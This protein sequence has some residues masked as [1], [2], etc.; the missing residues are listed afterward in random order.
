L[1]PAQL[2]VEV[3]MNRGINEFFNKQYTDAIHTFNTLIRSRPDMAEPHVWRGRAKY[4]IGDLVG[5]EFDLT[6]AVKLDTYNPDAYYYRGVVKATL[7]DYYSAIEDFKKS[8]QR[9]PNNPDVYFSRG[10]TR[11]YMEEFEAAI[12]DFDTLI[13]LRPDAEQS[14]LN[15]AQA[16]ANLNRIDEAIK[17]C[18]YVIKKNRFNARAFAQRALLFRDQGRFDEAI[19][20]FNQAIKLDNQNPL[21]YF[22]R[23]LA[24]SESGDTLSALND[25]NQVVR[26]DPYND[27]T[28]FNRSLIYLQSE[29]YDS[30]IEDLQKVLEL[31]PQNLHSW[32]NLGVA[33]LRIE[34]Y[35]EAAKSLTAAINILPYYL[36]AYRAR[37]VAYENLGKDDLA[38]ADFK[39]INRLI[40]ALDS[41]LDVSDLN[42]KLE[43]D[44]AYIK[45]II[46][47]EAD[48]QT[49]NVTDGRVQNQ[50]VIIKMLPNY[51]IQ[52]LTEDELIELERKFMN[53]N[54]RYDHLDAMVLGYGFGISSDENKLPE[55]FA[56]RL[57]R[58]SDS[59]SYFD[60]FNA[61]N[62]FRV[63]TFNAM[64]RNYNEALTSFDRAIE[65]NPNFTEA[66]FNRAN[67]MF[68]LIEHRFSMEQDISKV[69]ISQ[70]SNSAGEQD[71][72]EELPDFSQVIA[73]LDKVIRV[74]P[75]FSIAYYNRGNTKNRRRD[76]QGAV[77][78]YTAAL[79][80][81]PDFAEAYYNR[82]ITL[83]YFNHTR[84]ACYDLSKAGE[85]GIKEAYN[86]IKRFCNK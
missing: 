32:Y 73:D 63:G 2:N 20:D 11:L 13:L 51:S 33:Y 86:V 66:Y 72:R 49:A 52:Y 76:F 10:V 57:V 85:L 75:K 78:D 50:R 69:T 79:A 77:N 84:E 39:T 3:F 42:R 67:I 22:N 40:D 61:Q 26:L 80:L 17:D 1:L 54:I 43:I 4:E 65:L 58:K 28:Y 15:R 74:N 70:G 53:T 29:Q 71:Q 83:I 44:S 16:K 23:A 60:P 46:D 8:L 36:E 21:T 6:R 59:I 5:A 7:Y 55:G 48:F 56:D 31:N 81:N 82:A 14:F 25:F 27:I 47:F 18:N 64:M 30:A 62:Y 9:R 41:G 45:R 38:D 12:G 34:N 35:E 19:S 24:F 37:M 68:E